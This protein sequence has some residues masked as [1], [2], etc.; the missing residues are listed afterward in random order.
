MPRTAAGTTQ[1]NS[2]GADRPGN[3]FSGQESNP[4]ATKN[5]INIMLYPT[6][7]GKG[8]AVFLMF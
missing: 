8:P 3:N 1:E 7:M 6:K 4:N 5:A 2:K